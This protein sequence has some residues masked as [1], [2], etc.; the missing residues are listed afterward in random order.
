MMDVK[1]L[2]ITGYSV[3]GRKLAGSV[4][5][6]FWKQEWAFLVSRLRGIQLWSTQMK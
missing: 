1:I 2:D 5:N 6:P 3:I 4:S